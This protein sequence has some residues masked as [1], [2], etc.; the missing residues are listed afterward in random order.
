MTSYGQKRTSSQ[1]SHFLLYYYYF[2]NKQKWSFYENSLSCLMLM[3]PAPLCPNSL[4]DW[5][6]GL[7]LGSVAVCGRTGRTGDSCVE[8]PAGFHAWEWHWSFKYKCTPEQIT[9]SQ[10]LPISCRLSIRTDPSCSPS[11]SRPQSGLCAHN[12][13]Q[14]LH[15][16]HSGTAEH[17]RSLCLTFG[18]LWSNTQTHGLCKCRAVLALAVKAEP[19]RPAQTQRAAME[20]WM[21]R[22]VSAKQL[23]QAQRGEEKRHS[24]A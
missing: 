11:D 3:D 18:H 12:P 21:S 2:F 6:D 24:S 7:V 10:Y 9:L 13:S 22:I 20:E 5:S 1:Q 17:L 19:A 23:L 14:L 8:L 16:C 15:N 4:S